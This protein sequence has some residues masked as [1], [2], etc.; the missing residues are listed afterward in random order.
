MTGFERK[1]PHRKEKMMI[2]RIKPM[3]RFRFLM[4]VT[5]G[6]L[7]ISCGPKA[8]QPLSQLDTPE[9]HTFTG[10][11]LLNQ[12]KFVDA[13]REFEL[14]LRLQRPMSGSGLSPPIKATSQADST[15]SSRRR[16]TPGVMRRKSSSGWVTSV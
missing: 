8:Q 4:V 16:S 11:R 2:N 15:P 6:L 3:S 12:E 10:I 1:I 5:V 9:H 14:A 13:G 7:M